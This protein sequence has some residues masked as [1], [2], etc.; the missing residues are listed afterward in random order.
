MRRALLAATIVLVTS[1]EILAWSD[2][3]HKIIASIA[4]RRLTA[5]ERE[6]AVAILREH[7]RFK[8]DFL[9]KLPSDLV[10]DDRNEW[11]FQQ[12]AVWPDIA[13][14][15]RGEDAKFHHSTWHYINLPSYLN[16]SDKEAL[17][18]KIK[19]N[20]SLEPPAKP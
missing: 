8:A 13:R 18:G 4:F 17:T 15:F 19:V 2:A 1:T 20:D 16:D 7:P 9:D 11:I 10:D 3:G 5:E 12:A 6:K 14:G